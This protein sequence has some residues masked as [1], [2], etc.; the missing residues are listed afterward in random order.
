MKTGNLILDN[1]K[2]KILKFDTNSNKIIYLDKSLTDFF[3]N[4][5]VLIISPYPCKNLFLF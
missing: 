5:K 3:V 1:L 2:R 4:K